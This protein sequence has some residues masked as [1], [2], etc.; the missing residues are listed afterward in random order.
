MNQHTPTIWERIK[1]WLFYLLPH[2]F[3]SRIIF[4]LSRLETSWKDPLVRAYIKYFNVNMLDAERDSPADYRSFDAFFTRRLR[5]E[6]RPVCDDAKTLAAPCDGTILEHG[7]ITETTLFQAKEQE[8]TLF[9]L[10]GGRQTYANY[11]KNGK[12]CSIYLAPNDYH[13]VHMPV[14]GHLEM[15]THVPGRLF[16][17]APYA[18]RLIPRLYALNERVITVFTTPLGKIAIILIGAMNV[19]AIETV[20]HGLV[21]PSTHRITCFDYVADKPVYLQRGDEMGC[22]H[23]GSTVILL[24]DDPQIQWNP[25]YLSDKTIR[26]GEEIACYLLS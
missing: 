23:L 26:M 22:F 18:L 19:G 2:H 6:S 12:F 13:R 14:N 11:F 3:L 15:M 10:F 17:V 24:S 5:P 1:V 9:D 21:T 4:Y 16:S 20:W 8:Y 7:A 25:A